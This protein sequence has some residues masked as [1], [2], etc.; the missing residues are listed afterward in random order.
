MTFKDYAKDRWLT[1]VM[2][3]IELITAIVIGFVV[4]IHESIIFALILMFTFFIVTVLI[5]KSDYKQF[6]TMNIEYQERIQAEKDFCDHMVFDNFVFRLYDNGEFDMDLLGCPEEYDDDQA[7]QWLK[8][9]IK[10]L[11]QDDDQVKDMCN[12]INN[13]KSEPHTEYVVGESMKNIMKLKE[14]K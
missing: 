7:K 10:K 14:N 8:G 11:V 1:I 4:F 6:V 5:I 3:L 9:Y 12:V 2:C 13:T